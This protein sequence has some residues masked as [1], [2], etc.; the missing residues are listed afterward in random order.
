MMFVT[1]RAA[2]V[3]VLVGQ[4]RCGRGGV[5]DRQKV[6][7]IPRAME[8]GAIHNLHN[9]ISDTVFTARARSNA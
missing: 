2:S 8:A 4:G 3:S 9:N 1:A 6:A 5:Q 7:P